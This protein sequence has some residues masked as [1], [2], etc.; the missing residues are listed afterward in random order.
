MRLMTFPQIK[1]VQQRLCSRMWIVERIQ[2]TG[3]KKSI[4]FKVK[5]SKTNGSVYVSDNQHP[6]DENSAAVP[7]QTKETICIFYQLNRPKR[8]VTQEMFC[9]KSGAKMT[10]R[11]YWTCPNK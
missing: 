10:K 4:Y 7:L 2:K 8:L 6:G 9:E 3:C 11:R 5:K 1:E